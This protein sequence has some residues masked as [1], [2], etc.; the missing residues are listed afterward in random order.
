[1]GSGSGAGEGAMAAS[2]APAD[3]RAAPSTSPSRPVIFAAAPAAGEEGTLL[4]AAGIGGP[5]PIQTASVLDLQDFEPFV[6]A[7]KALGRKDYAEARQILGLATD[8]P[9]DAALLES[10]L[11]LRDACKEFDQGHAPEASKLFPRAEAIPRLTSS[12]S[13]ALAIRTLEQFVAGT[14][15]APDDPAG[16]IRL[17]TELAEQ[18]RTEAFF[19][20]DF[21]G[22]AQATEIA[23]LRI[24]ARA[25]LR[26]HEVTTYEL[27]VGKLRG[28]I[29]RQIA[30]TGNEPVWLL[31]VI[32]AQ[33][34]VDFAVQRGLLDLDELDVESMR[35]HLDLGR[36]YADGMEPLLTGIPPESSQ[37]AEPA[38]I[39]RELYRLIDILTSKLE[40][41]LVQGARFDKKQ[42]QA[43]RTLRDDL[44]RLRG[45]VGKLGEVAKAWVPLLDR[46]EHLATRV[47]SIGAP[48]NEDFGR[49]SGLVTGGAFVV[50]SIVIF[51]VA[52]PEQ[53]AA[54]LVLVI[55]LVPSAII[56]FGYGAL[57]F[58]PLFKIVTQVVT[59]FAKGGAGKGA[60]EKGKE[61]KGKDVSSRPRDSTESQEGRPE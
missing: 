12:Q 29:D 10:A 28:L 4:N 23:I 21:R 5:L 34:E 38:R 52:R 55:L 22:I 53:G 3:P 42:L 31:N 32:R 37:L 11:A 25:A 56:G 43:L 46:L 14:A 20:D 30:E 41:A 9:S 45:R 54:P 8:E 35:Q 18:I 33:I 48:R 15:L 49:F 39:T 50:L 24:A 26:K 7:L 1:M 51:T 61:N 57:K 60:E 6:K 2:P 47:V 13:L 36:A 44:I 27:A 19:S 58:L 16:A 59:P 17:L 40:V